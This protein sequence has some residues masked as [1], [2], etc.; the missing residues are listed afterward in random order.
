MKD[1]LMGK[2]DGDTPSTKEYLKEES[3]IYL[4]FPIEYIMNKIN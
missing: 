4:N 3:R 1:P 2:M